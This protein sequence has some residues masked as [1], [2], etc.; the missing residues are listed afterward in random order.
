M[1]DLLRAGFDRHLVRLYRPG[2]WGLTPR[3][4]G[5]RSPGGGQQKFE[6]TPKAE[7]YSRGV[8]DTEDVRFLLPVDNARPKSGKCGSQAQPYSPPSYN[9][10][11]RIRNG[12]CTPYGAFPWTVQIQVRNNGGRFKHLCGGSLVSDLFVL[13]AQHCFTA[14]YN[15]AD[16]RVVVGQY[17]MKKKDKQEMAFEVDWKEAHPKFRTN[18]PQSHDLAIIKLKPKGDGGAGFG[19][20]M[21]ATVSPICIPQPGEHFKDDLPCVVSGWGQILPKKKVRGE[22]LRAA[23][24]PLINQA[25]CRRMYRDSSQPLIAGQI[26]AGYEKGMVDT[27]HGDSGGPLACQTGDGSYKL[28]GIVNWGGGYCG[29]PGKPGVYTR[30]QYYDKW[31]QE[32]MG[33]SQAGNVL[34]A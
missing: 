11:P 1:E 15:M 14:I 13:T 12:T 23:Q 8:A 18:G 28:V 25:S 26:C 19:V 20:K 5:R 34:V 3:T 27:C 22:C 30:V 4:R 16:V 10:A 2:S 21:S 6:T 33:G 32:M 24:V 31:I 7:P 9:R 17:N 29:E